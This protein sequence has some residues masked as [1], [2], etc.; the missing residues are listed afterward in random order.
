MCE[1]FA[2]MSKKSIRSP[3]TVLQM[4]ESHLG[5]WTWMLLIDESTLQYTFPI[6]HVH[7]CVCVCWNVWVCKRHLRMKW[8][9][10]LSLISLLLYSLRLVSQWI[11]ELTGM[12]G[13]TSQLALW[14]LSLTS[15]P[16]IVGRLPL[17][18]NIYMYHMNSQ[19]V[20][21][22]CLGRTYPL[23]QLSSPLSCLNRNG[24]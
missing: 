24:F 17:V 23:I 21:L 3:G 18:P 15:Q 22:A 5:N 9:Q 10:E 6:F 16:G 7:V 20:P 14:I 1:Y 12:T 19:S 8:C 2:C 11:P 4:V 13:I